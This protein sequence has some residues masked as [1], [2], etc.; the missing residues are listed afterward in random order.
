L[1]AFSVSGSDSAREILDCKRRRL[2]PDIKAG[3]QNPFL[4][5]KEQYTNFF[6]YT[7]KVLNSNHSI[8]KE[9]GR[10]SLEDQ[11]MYLL[12]SINKVFESLRTPRTYNDIFLEVSFLKCI[13]DTFT[14]V[15]ISSDDFKNYET[16]QDNTQ[17]QSQFVKD[18][19]RTYETDKPIFEIILDLIFVKPITLNV[20]NKQFKD[21]WALERTW[22]EFQGL[23]NAK[24]F[25]VIHYIIEKL[26]HELNETRKDVPIICT[27]IIKKVLQKNSTDSTERFQKYLIETAKKSNNYNFLFLMCRMVKWDKCLG[28]ESL[29]L[30]CL[31][32]QE[33]LAIT[34]GEEKNKSLYAY[35]AYIKGV[36]DALRSETYYVTR[37]ECDI[38]KNLLP[39][40]LKTCVEYHMSDD[41]FKSLLPKFYEAVFDTT[42]V[43]AVSETDLENSS[44]NTVINAIIDF[45]KFDLFEHVLDSFPK[46]Q[47][48]KQNMIAFCLQKLMQSTKSSPLEIKEFIVMCHKK[49]EKEKINLLKIFY[50]QFSKDQLNKF[51]EIM[52]LLD[53]QCLEDDAMPSMYTL[54]LEKFMAG[55]ESN[56]NSIYIKLCEELKSL[57]EDES[58]Q[59]CLF[60]LDQISE[61]L[62]QH[63]NNFKKLQFSCEAEYNLLKNLDSQYTD[64]AFNNFINLVDILIDDDTKTC[65][66]LMN[67]FEVTSLP[68]S[69]LMD[70]L[71]NADI[72]GL[73]V[74]NN[75]SA[76]VKSELANLMDDLD[77]LKKNWDSFPA[78]CKHPFLFQKID[79]LMG[80]ISQLPIFKIVSNELDTTTSA[81]DNKIIASIQ[82]CRAEIRQHTV[83]LINS[84]AP[85]TAMVMKG[86]V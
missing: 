78:I 18:T 61:N 20:G 81:E 7:N 43:V 3:K 53:Q 48:E 73:K 13:I 55:F 1:S 66:K 38:F 12:W 72:R 21:E 31:F 58:K 59:K 24:N 15:S 56:D 67:N 9:I 64:S 50:S 75:K 39:F 16:F 45:K 19:F 79:S 25:V 86:G 41:E 5:I 29:E 47:L 17:P 62:I 35:T 80:W 22:G 14:N 33:Q 83:P 60:F 8:F 57:K 37:A 76:D 11:K 30:K 28:A 32:D 27:A 69:G 10:F 26:S 65:T 74:W 40:L 52:E 71:I 54:L 51:A 23:L 36:H 84:I 49:Y 70:A 44:I 46:T 42:S 85:K 77:Y 34:F 63:V 82:S 4:S 68:L 6:A 2:N